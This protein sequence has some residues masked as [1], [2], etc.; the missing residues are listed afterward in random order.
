[1]WGP[2]AMR[3]DPCAASTDV[4]QVHS[5]KGA[6]SSWGLALRR[7]G[8]PPP[9]RAPSAFGELAVLVSFLE[10]DAYVI[11]WLKS[12]FCSSFEIIPRYISLLKIRH[13]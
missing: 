10:R 4:T 6:S 2:S 7:Q 11:E 5:T 1:M 3:G 9:R 12:G 13:C 8:K